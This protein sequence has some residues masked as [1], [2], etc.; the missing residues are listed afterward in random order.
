MR[1]IR[2][3]ADLKRAS[4]EDVK[5]AMAM[6]SIIDALEEYLEWLY[7]SETKTVVT[8]E[9][10]RWHGRTLGIHPS[11]ACKKGVCLLKLYYDC[12]EE[13]APSRAYDAV[14]QRTWDIGTLLHDSYQ[15][16]LREM[17]GD[18]FQDEVK[19]LDE[20][21]HV[22]SRADGLFNFDLVKSV[23]EMKSIKE[24]GNFGW[25]KVQSA[26][27][28]D[29]V[30]QSHFYMKLSD[31]PFANILYMNKNA[32]HLKEHVV[33]FDFDLWEEIQTEVIEPVIAAAYGDGPRVEGTA[34]YGCRSCDYNYACPAVKQE[35]KHVKGANRA[36]AKRR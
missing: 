4:Q 8:A 9:L 13:L 6:V 14:M 33:V 23:L 18:Q 25:N 12:T 32:G 28:D 10:K 16:H 1:P 24:G 2:T 5:Q 31:A 22:K 7:H 30:R 29:N 34:G 11:S 27:M 19:L 17:F 21:L 20:E 15:V 26:P 3:L 35:R 36:W